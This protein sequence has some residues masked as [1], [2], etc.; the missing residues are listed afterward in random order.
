MINGK[1]IHI[2]HSNTPRRTIDNNN[3]D[4]TFF[5]QHKYPSSH[6]K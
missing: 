1:T 2:T 5:G 6:P 4:N 3:D